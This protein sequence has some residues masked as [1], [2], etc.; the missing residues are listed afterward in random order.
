M[1]VII[2]EKD[3][4]FATSIEAP[5]VYPV[6]ANGQESSLL[7]D[8]IYI[9]DN[10]L[11]F[12]L[13]LNDLEFENYD[14]IRI[15]PLNDSEITAIELSQFPLTLDKNI[16]T[17]LFDPSNDV[18]VYQPKEKINSIE[19]ELKELN[20]DVFSILINLKDTPEENSDVYRLD[21][22]RD[23]VGKTKTL[24]QATYS[25][26]FN[27]RFDYPKNLDIVSDQAIISNIL[28]SV[29]GDNDFTGLFCID[30]RKLVNKYTKFPT[31][32]DVSD[33]L[34][35][36]SFIFQ[37]D[38]FFYR[39]KDDE[40]GYNFTDDVIKILPDKVD[41]ILV[42]NEE[43]YRFYQFDFK[44]VDQ[45]YEYQVVTNLYFDDITI[46]LA[47]QKIVDVKT[48]KENDQRSEAELVFLDFYS[49]EEFKLEY[50]FD[51]EEIDRIPKIDFDLLVD[52]FIS[53]IQRKINNFSDKI[54]VS[55]NINRQYTSPKMINS[56]YYRSLLEEKFQQKINFG[57]KEKNNFFNNFE[58][59][60]GFGSLSFLDFAYQNK[61]LNVSK[62]TK[63]SI[64]DS[65][66]K[67][68]KF[69]LTSNKDKTVVTSGLTSKINTTDSQQKTEKLLAQ[70]LKQE[71]L[72]FEQIK[73]RG[74]KFYYLKEVADEAPTL[75]FKEV[76]DDFPS[77]EGISGKILV[78][79]D[80]YEEFYNSY[81]YVV[82]TGEE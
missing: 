54:V 76:D 3:I 81:F 80:N 51:L 24:D 45:R 79:T 68:D 28:Y 56:T 65:V 78:R 4:K 14:E 19:I 44:L 60:D 39:Y 59:D 21:V 70:S 25:E 58:N 77:L 40:T 7:V 55:S 57:K 82:G 22:L 8:N 62:E 18:V 64:A 16:E 63:F 6:V 12:D 13:F 50:N 43:F 29:S 66:E 37:S 35:F 1:S 5:R 20:S 47:K 74:V 42:D 15:I 26:V 27:K 41:D 49:E 61:K 48:F 32:I 69:I 75:I 71:L 33:N 72:S 2:D 34:I 46:N 9:K 30:K 38:I 11:V 31:L 73:S 36:D 23:L 17:I 10:K 52:R 67:I 53:D